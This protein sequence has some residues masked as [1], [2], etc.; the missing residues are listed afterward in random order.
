MALNRELIGKVYPP[1]GA[2]KAT[3]EKIM[4]YAKAYDDENELYFGEAVFAPPI[5]G[6]VAAFEAMLQPI[7]DPKLKCNV[8]KLV[9]GEHYMRFHRL[10]RSGDEISTEVTIQDIQEKSS[11]E[12]LTIALE[13]VDSQ[14]DK[15]MSSLGTFFIRGDKK[16]EGEK[17]KKAEEEEKWSEEIFNTGKTVAPDQSRRYAEASGDRN[18]IHIDEKFAKSVG[19]P[20]IILHGMCTLAIAHKAIIDNVLAK[21]PARL[22]S[23]SARF[24]GIVLMGDTLSTSGGWLPFTP[25][26]SEGNHRLMGF[27]TVNQKGEKS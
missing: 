7:F 26:D 18:F 12:L 22:K 21:D 4:K 23:L 1:K 25:G 9:H 24:S 13:S 17:D 8:M 27:E 14:N 19:L 2:F 6:Y 20:G 15:V 10:I 5:Y 11:G 3:A 16:G